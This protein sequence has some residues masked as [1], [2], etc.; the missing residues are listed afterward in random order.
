MQSYLSHL[1]CTACG[2]NYSADEPHRTC[3]VC[4]KVLYARYDIDSVRKAV[5]QRRPLVTPQ[6]HVAFLRDDA[7]A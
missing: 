4:G 2:E 3:P 1:E 5:G 6:Q 7:G